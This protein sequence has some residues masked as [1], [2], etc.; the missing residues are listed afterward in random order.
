MKQPR[1][2]HFLCGFALAV[3][4]VA[5]L[6]EVFLRLFP[7][8]DFH[9]YLGERN[10]RHGPYV[11]DADF[12][13]TYQNWDLFANDHA[14]RLRFLGPL[15]PT[16]TDARPLWAFFGN[17]FVHAPGM[18]ADT[19]RQNL[20]EK[21]IFNLGRNEHICVRL[22]QIRLLLDQ[23]LQ[24]ERIFIELM[25]LDVAILGSH[26]LESIHVT[27]RGALTY[28]PR[29]PA[30]GGPLLER[31]ALGRAAWFRSGQQKPK[32]SFHP[33][34]LNHKVADYLLHDLDHL[35]GRVSQITGQRHIPVTMILIPNYEQ[36]MEGAPFAFQ[37]QLTP[38]FQKHGLDVFDARACFFKETDRPGLFLPDKHL[39]PRGN[40]M[41]LSALLEHVHH[42]E[43]PSLSTVAERKP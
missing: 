31:S 20:H 24:P 7:P 13:L 9:D 18:L 10:P 32:P 22:A 30:V 42:R 11:P 40:R 41:L 6:G 2:W 39:T 26:P 5:G 35:F 8:R 37:E 17:S 15:A 19:A 25:P 1:R 29:W 36:V 23:G 27:R 16:S 28:T 4:L 14:E 33:R 43:G 12:G 21:R 3:L 38:L 34:Q